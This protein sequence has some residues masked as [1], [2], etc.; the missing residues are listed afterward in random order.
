MEMFDELVE[1]KISVDGKAVV[2]RCILKIDTRN[3]WRPDAPMM[4]LAVEPGRTEG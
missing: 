4:K 1:M 2:K 3:C